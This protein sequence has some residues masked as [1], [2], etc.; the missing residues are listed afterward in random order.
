M[1]IAPLSARLFRFLAVVASA[2]LIVL[3]LGTGSHADQNVSLVLSPTISSKSPIFHWHGMIQLAEEPP[4]SEWNCAKCIAERTN[5][6]MEQTECD[7]T[8][9]KCLSICQ[10]T[11]NMDMDCVRLCASTD[12]QGEGQRPLS[13]EPED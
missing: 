9:Y 8:D 13:D 10:S 1:S 4:S 7:R 2:A 6:C 5:E 3:M 11:A 12:N